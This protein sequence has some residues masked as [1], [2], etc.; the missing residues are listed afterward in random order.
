M[1]LNSRC[2]M[3]PKKRNYD[4]YRSIVGMISNK[5]TVVA[6]FVAGFLKHYPQPT[7]R[8]V[9]D[10]AIDNFPS[11]NDAPFTIGLTPPKPG[12][13]EGPHYQYPGDSAILS[14]EGVTL[15][16]LVAEIEG[17][18]IRVDVDPVRAQVAY[19]A[20]LLVYERNKALSILGHPDPERQANVLS[21]TYNGKV[22]AFH[23]HYVQ[24]DEYGDLQYHMADIDYTDIT[25]SPPTYALVQRQVHNAQEYAKHAAE[26]L[27]DQLVIHFG[28]GGGSNAGGGGDGGSG[29]GGGGR[30][31]G[32]RRAGRERGDRRERKRNSRGQF[33]KRSGGEVDG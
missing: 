16:H 15:P 12:L 27:R 28:R 25:Y 3:P 14:S 9:F 13:I 20:A 5:A 10:Q 24:R 17:T 30:G 1:I 19:S 8:K 31:R 11:P 18:S 7:Y 33:V 2:Q 23:G 4:Q 21:I 26:A 6:E 22:I 29:E 32:N